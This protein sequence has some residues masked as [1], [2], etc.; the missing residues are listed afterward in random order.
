MIR[1]LLEDIE[2]R[3]LNEGLKVGDTV[4]NGHLRVHRYRGS[5]EVT[6]LTN[7]GKKGK[8]VRQFTIDNIDDYRMK[9]DTDTEALYKFA[10]FMST[11]SDYDRALHAAKNFT[12][13]TTGKVHE[14]EKK[15]IHVPMGSDGFH[16]NNMVVKYD[17]T[18]FSISDLSDTINAPRAIPPVSNGKSDIKKFFNFMNNE[19]TKKRIA[20][21]SY[22][23]FL[24]ELS[25]QGIH[26]HS[27]LSND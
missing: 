23:D 14:G 13:I 15:G 11:V 24:R 8:T 27:Y 2:A 6:D 26:Y 20:N 16:N 19:F 1:Q 25:K 12:E 9:D 21:M 7:A 4:E 10:G 18:S 17:S 22:D 3:V 5:M